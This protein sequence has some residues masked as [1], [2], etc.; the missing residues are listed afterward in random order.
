MDGWRCLTRTCLDALL[1][2]RGLCGG[3]GA[4]RILAFVLN[5][6]LRLQ[7]WTEKTNNANEIIASVGFERRVGHHTVD[8]GQS[9]LHQ[10]DD[11]Y[12]LFMIIYGKRMVDWRGWVLRKRRTETRP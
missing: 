10:Y 4:E 1:V 8:T 7:N 2:R 6:F 9:Y 3:S 12:Q 11:N 5:T